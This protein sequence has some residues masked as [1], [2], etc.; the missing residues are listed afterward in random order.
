[1]PIE[2][3]NFSNIHLKG[4]DLVSAPSSPCP[5]SPLTLPSAD[6]IQEA[7]TVL[8]EEYSLGFLISSL[9]KFFKGV[10]NTCPLNKGDSKVV[11]YDTIKHLR[12][13]ELITLMSILNEYQPSLVRSKSSS[14]VT[15]LDYEPFLSISAETYTRNLVSNGLND[16]SY[17]L[18]LLVWSPGARR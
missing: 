12:K 8:S 13:E 14:L 3:E 1:M 17:N 9:F 16:G 10:K 18:I 2:F 5:S 7:D 15:F 6:I 4:T 11:L